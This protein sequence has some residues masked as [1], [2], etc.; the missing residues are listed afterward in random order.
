MA[1]ISYLIDKQITEVSYAE[2]VTL[3]EAKLYIRVSHTSEDAEIS[4]MI[5][6]ARQIIEQ[7]T[8]QSLIT[9]QV[10][11]WFSNKG[12][13]FQFPYGP[14]TSS[15][16]LY[17]NFTG[18]VVVDK[19]IIGDG[20]PVITF[21]VTD[22]LKAVY[23]VGYNPIPTALKYAILDQVN[24]LYENRRAGAEGMGVCEKAWRA[25]QMYTKRSPIL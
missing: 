25:C 12:G 9:K 19:T 23:N 3:A 14:I 15:I 10:T 17:D 4:E 1:N 11:I 13:F 6:T 16:T 8:G 5:R 22:N 24:H 18:S 21:P 2:P 20:N 7:G